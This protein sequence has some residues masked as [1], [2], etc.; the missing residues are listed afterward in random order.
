MRFKVLLIVLLLGIEA[1]AQ[2]RSSA[3][4]YRG[5]AEAVPASATDFERQI[6]TNSLEVPLNDDARAFLKRCDRSL[7]LFDAASQI[8]FGTWGFDTSDRLQVTRPIS[9]MVELA[10][11]VVL[12]ARFALAVG[13]L[14]DALDDCYTLAVLAR[15]MSVQPSLARL[16]QQEAILSCS[17]TLAGTI[18]PKA[19]AAA[20]TQFI[21][22]L[23][24]LRSP[25]DA[26]A[27]A[28]GERDVYLWFHGQL[29]DDP[30]LRRL[31]N[32]SRQA[33]GELIDPKSSRLEVQDLVEDPEKRVAIFAETTTAFDEMIQAL[34]EPLEQRDAALQAAAA[35]FEKS[36]VLVRGASRIVL[37]I[38]QLDR[39]Q[40][41]MM[42]RIK[43]TAEQRTPATQSTERN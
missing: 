25:A 36:H 13:K 3:D 29:I 34:N 12:R 40:A 42:Q 7:E 19:S 9:R 2:S 21:S 8:A 20:S 22:R 35:K 38:H 23:E 41:A 5:A 14:S 33:F 32:S 43:A 31:V 28:K 10:Q 18:L 30:M 6:L 39:S 16:A 27:I 26:V 11:V 15:R 17:L 37:R 24:E 4:A 1:A